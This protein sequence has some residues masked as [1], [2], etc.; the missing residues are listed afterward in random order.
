MKYVSNE[1]DE[2]SKEI[3]LKNTNKLLWLNSGCI[4]GKTGCNLI[5]GDSVAACYEGNIIVVVLGCH[6]SQE[7]FADC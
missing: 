5:G 4:G 3:P 2:K 1:G 6:G 7:K